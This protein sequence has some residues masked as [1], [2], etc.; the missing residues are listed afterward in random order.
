MQTLSNLTEIDSLV[1]SHDFLF[2]AQ[3]PKLKRLRLL[4]FQQSHLSRIAGKCKNLEL[5]VLRIRSCE[6]RNLSSKAQLGSIG[7]FS[8]LLILDLICDFE[9]VPPF[10]KLV[11]LRELILYSRNPLSP[12]LCDLIGKEVSN[13]VQ[14]LSVFLTVTQS[15]EII[16]R[17]LQLTVLRVTTATRFGFRKFCVAFCETRA[18]PKQMFIRSGQVYLLNGVISSGHPLDFEKRYLS[19]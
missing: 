3:L 8:N 5:L 15:A 18:N 19:C 6:V 4:L 11:K 9:L 2:P 13:S 17:Y 12:A 1:S 10:S 16:L 7:A 14:F